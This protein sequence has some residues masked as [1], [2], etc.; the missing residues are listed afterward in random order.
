MY[1]TDMAGRT[2][3]VGHAYWRICA[4]ACVVRTRSR[5]RVVELRSCTRNSHVS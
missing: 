4:C 2:V 1:G 3:Y 5:S